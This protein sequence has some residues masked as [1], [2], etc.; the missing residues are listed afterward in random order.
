MDGT[1]TSIVGIILG[2]DFLHIKPKNTYTSP[3]SNNGIIINTF[4]EVNI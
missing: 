4:N 3:T 2:E 1:N